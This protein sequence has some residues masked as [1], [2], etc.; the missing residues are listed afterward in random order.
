[1]T[2]VPSALSG[3][4]AGWELKLE[5]TQD[6]CLTGQPS[7]WGGW[8]GRRRFSVGGD[9]GAGERTCRRLHAG[10]GSYLRRCTS[11]GGWPNLGLLACRG[12]GTPSLVA[13]EITK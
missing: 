11:G 1:M 10:M 6:R 12:L 2:S 8:S 4:D 7:Y 3:R 5:I 9:D 13:V